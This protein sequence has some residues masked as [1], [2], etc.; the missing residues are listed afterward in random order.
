MLFL[1]VMSNRD[2]STFG[3]TELVFII[4]TFGWVLDQFVGGIPSRSIFRHRL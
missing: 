4:Y 1:L 3:L 2:A